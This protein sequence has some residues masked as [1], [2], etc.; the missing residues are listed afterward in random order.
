MGGIAGYF[1]GRP[2]ALSL[3]PALWRGPGLLLGP[4]ALLLWLGVAGTALYLS[5]AF[6]RLSP[7][8]EAFSYLVDGAVLLL[9]VGAAGLILYRVF[10]D[11]IRLDPDD[12]IM[13][14]VEIIAAIPS[15][16]LLISLRAVF[17]TNI[18][19]SSPSTWWW[20]FWASLAGE[21]WPGWCGGS[22][23]P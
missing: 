1:S 17:P 4:L 6:V 9:G 16:F 13:R 21:G 11:P 8:R 22:C 14:T 10:R 15:L 19:P 2:F 3:P 12:L 20:G 18:D 23:F 5:L 7:G